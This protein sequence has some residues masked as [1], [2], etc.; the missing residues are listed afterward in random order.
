MRIQ[1]PTYSEYISSQYRFLLHQWDSLGR[2]I[3]IRT[4]T[5]NQSWRGAPSYPCL[6]TAAADQIEALV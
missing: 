2:M 3:H 4:A 6:G 5:E 1:I